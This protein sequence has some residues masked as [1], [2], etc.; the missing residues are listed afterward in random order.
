MLLL[1]KTSLAAVTTCAF[2]A[3]GCLSS[4]ANPESTPTPDKIIP[5][6]VSYEPPEGY[7]RNPD[8]PAAPEWY[9][10]EHDRLPE[11]ELRFTNAELIFG[12]DA[13]SF[14]QH[15]SWR[16]LRKRIH[17]PR[18]PHGGIRTGQKVSEVV[19]AGGKALVVTLRLQPY[20][21]QVDYWAFMWIPVAP[22]QF[23]EGHVSAATP[24]LRDRLLDSLLKIRVHRYWNIPGS[25]AKAG[26]EP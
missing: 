5:D 11:I 8:A 21:H 18:W 24:E 4:P 9:H 22:N 25:D 6:F 19:L 1:P 15:P 13:E 26:N 20:E 2:S 10:P 17:N 23:V 14:K 7:V 16:A 3:L 12:E